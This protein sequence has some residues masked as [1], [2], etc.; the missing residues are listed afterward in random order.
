MTE[1]DDP[2]VIE[3]V[4]VTATELVTAL[5][6]SHRTG[7]PDTVLRVTTPFSGRTRARLHVERGPDVSG[8]PPICLQA[9]SLVEDT[10]PALPEPDDVEDA[11]RADPAATYSIDRHQERYRDALDEWRASV[12]DHVVE[13]VRLPTTDRD[14][15][16]SILGTVDDG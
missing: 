4:V 11:L 3:H 1:S 16:I 6:S 13:T 15:T 2:A 10:C 14:V 9:Q 12:P 8:P 7:G 5:E